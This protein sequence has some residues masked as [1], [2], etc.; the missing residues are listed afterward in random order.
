M[1]GIIT[2]VSPNYLS[3]AFMY[4]CDNR[5]NACA[6]VSIRLRGYRVFHDSPK[7]RSFVDR[8]GL[9]VV[10]SLCSEAP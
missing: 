7:Y 2:C 4:P 1:A 5:D 3:V 9:F 6:F 10:D 8:Q